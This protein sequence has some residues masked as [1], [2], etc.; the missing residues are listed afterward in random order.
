MKIY[1]ADPEYD[2]RFLRALDYAPLGAQMG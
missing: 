2:G 1:F